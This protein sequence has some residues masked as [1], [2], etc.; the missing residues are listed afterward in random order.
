MWSVL[1]LI[2]SNKTLLVLLVFDWSIELLRHT[3]YQGLSIDSFI[4]FQQI[5]PRIKGEERVNRAS[6]ILGS[7]IREFTAESDQSASHQVHVNENPPWIEWC[8]RTSRREAENRHLSSARER[9]TWSTHFDRFLTSRAEQQWQPFST[10][11]SS[12]MQCS[13]HTVIHRLFIASPCRWRIQ[14]TFIRS[15]PV[16]SRGR[17]KPCKRVLGMFVY[18]FYRK[19]GKSIFSFSWS[20]SSLLFLIIK[21]FS[22]DK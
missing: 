21:S 8:N 16:W 1:S 15:W 6:S 3:H 13:S 12:T 20:S 22:V 19:K 18:I 11:M 9:R 4:Y 7:V 17:S 2:W 14:L 10:N 5:C